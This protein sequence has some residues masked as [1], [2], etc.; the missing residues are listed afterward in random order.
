V[1]QHIDF[2]VPPER[3]WAELTDFDRLGDWVAEHRGFPDGAPAEL[4]EGLRS[5]LEAAGDGTRM[6]YATRL[7]AIVEG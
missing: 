7:E 3:V 1:E 6:R 5:E 2:G 4:S